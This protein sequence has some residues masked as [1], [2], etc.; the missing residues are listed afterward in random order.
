MAD[1]SR[2][3]TGKTL[4]KRDLVTTLFHCYLPFSSSIPQRDPLLY[5]SQVSLPPHP[6]EHLSI[7][8]EC[9]SQHSGGYIHDLPTVAKVTVSQCLSSLSPTE[10][11][12]L[13]LAK[14]M[15]TQTKDYISQPPLQLVVAM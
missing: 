4:V 8:Q 6:R 12:T 13:K 2:P 10:R 14:H 1:S 5:T 7:N 9:P 15:V 11:E 3:H